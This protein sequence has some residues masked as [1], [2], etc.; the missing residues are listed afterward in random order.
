MSMTMGCRANNI[1]G[2]EFHDFAT[3]LLIICF[4][5]FLNLVK[6]RKNNVSSSGDTHNHR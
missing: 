4:D 2:R 6:Y 1:L 5:K 3:R